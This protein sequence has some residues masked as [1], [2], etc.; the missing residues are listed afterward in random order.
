[1][2]VDEVTVGKLITDPVVRQKYT[3][4]I[5]D[6]YVEVLF[7]LSLPL[8]S[9]L[10]CTVLHLFEKIINSQMKSLLI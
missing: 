5:A 1:M 9:I 6:A 7:S 4:M 10:F 3:K 8:F 2:Q